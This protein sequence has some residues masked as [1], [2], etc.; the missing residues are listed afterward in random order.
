MT[1]TKW[2]P[3]QSGNPRGRPRRK[4][5]AEHLGSD[6]PKVID[7]LKDAALKGDV[8]AGKVLLEKTAATPRPE[9]TKVTISGFEEA[10][11]P[12]DKADLIIKAAAAGEISPSVAQELMAALASTVRVIEVDELIR[13]IAAIEERLKGSL[14]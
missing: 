5:V 13:R 6:L 10:A 12:T 2:R 8:L 14:A 7:A 1:D 3:G 4:S 9:S 11:T